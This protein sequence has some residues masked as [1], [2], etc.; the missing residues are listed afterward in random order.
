MDSL[1]GWYV[2]SLLRIIPSGMEG[3]GG[4]R[5]HP[6]YFGQPASSITIVRSDAP[7]IMLRFFLHDGVRVGETAVFV[8]VGV[9]R[10]RK[11]VGGMPGVP[12][13]R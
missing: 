5:K 10:Q 1:S 7:T 11:S 8:W 6:P 4:G 2:G 3:C 12:Y 13:A 9:R